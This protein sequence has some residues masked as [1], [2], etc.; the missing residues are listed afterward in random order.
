MMGFLFPKCCAG[1]CGSGGHL[2]FH[3]HKYFWRDKRRVYFV[4]DKPQASSWQLV[5]LDIDSMITIL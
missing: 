5:K 3:L 4:P 2:G 1:E